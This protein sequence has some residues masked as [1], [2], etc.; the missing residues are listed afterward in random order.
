M[1][2]RLNGI[3]SLFVETTRFDDIGRRKVNAGLGGAA[4]GV[5]RLCMFLSSGLCMAYG[6]GV[7]NGAATIGEA[8][9]GKDSERSLARSAGVV[10][11][12]YESAG[13]G[14]IAF[15]TCPPVS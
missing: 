5:K 14:I 6:P 4:L 8:R 13:G 2:G 1:Y 15:S 9:M 10:C 11:L 7:V 3:G 12:E